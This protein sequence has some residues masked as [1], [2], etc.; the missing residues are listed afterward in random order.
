[1]TTHAAH[2][3]S[4][5]VKSGRFKVI[6]PLYCIVYYSNQRVVTCGSMGSSDCNRYQAGEWKSGAICHGSVVSFSDILCWN[7]GQLIFEVQISKK[8]PFDLYTTSTNTWWY[9]VI[10]GPTCWNEYDNLHLHL[11]DKETLPTICH[12]PKNRKRRSKKNPKNIARRD[13]S[14]EQYKSKELGEYID[15]ICASLLSSKSRS[16]VDYS[17]LVNQIQPI[18]ILKFQK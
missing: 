2:A 7:Y 11:G 18:Q 6:D 13:Y 12:L 14:M 15:S 1:M 9:T 8:R 4:K 10:W 5:K 17:F 3:A 16:Q